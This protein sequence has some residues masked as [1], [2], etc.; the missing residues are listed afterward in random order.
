MKAVIVEDEALAASRLEKLLSDVAPEINVVA[1]LSSVKEAVKWFTLN[2]ADLIFLDIQ[3]SDGLS[4][5]IFEEVTVN[6]PVIF[7]TAYD[8]Y[9]IKAFQLNSIDYLLKPIRK[10]ELQKSL[11]KYNSLKSAFKIDFE[12][13]LAGIQGKT[14]SYKKRF[15]IQVGSK[16]KTIET[17]DVAWFYADGK[18]VFL[19][20]FAGQNYP[21]DFSLDKLENMVDPAQ[22]FRINRKYMVNF[23]AIEGMVAWSRSRVKIKLNPPADDETETVVSI[24]RSPEF[25]KWL[26][27]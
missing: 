26:D 21:V 9:S 5:S 4:F 12:N 20:T 18:Y 27:K 23:D 19:K 24:D 8:Q 2:S 22:F 17:T 25:K 10:G 15:L 11:Q 13:L 3:L 6:T 16:I 1:R 14:E 7:T